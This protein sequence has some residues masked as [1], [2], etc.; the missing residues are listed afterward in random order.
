MFVGCTLYALHISLLHVAGFDG[1]R[2]VC[3]QKRTRVQTQIT[4][5]LCLVWAIGLGWAN[6]YPFLLPI[7]SSVLRL[8]EKYVLSSYSRA[9]ST[10]KLVEQLDSQNA[11]ESARPGPARGC[12]SAE[13]AADLGPLPWVSGCA[14]PQPPS[15]HASRLLRSSL[16]PLRA[17]PLPLFALEPA[18]VGTPPLSPLGKCVR[19]SSDAESRHHSYHFKETVISHKSLNT[20]KI[21]GGTGGV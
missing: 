15:H 9:V 20:Y 11:W 1:T 6:F 18:L 17:A 8:Q 2:S 4:V 16:L 12:P 21:S 19:H 13:Q 14:P 10:Q 5:Q 3:N 7:P